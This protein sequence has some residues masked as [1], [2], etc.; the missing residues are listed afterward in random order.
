MGSGADTTMNVV[1]AMAEHESR[2]V[3][4]LKVTMYRPWSAKHFMEV[5]PESV[6][7]ITVLDKTSEGG[8]HGNPLFLDVVATFAE[9]GRTLDLISGGVY[10]I[11]SKAFT[12]NMIK[13]VYD[14]MR[15]P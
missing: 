8:A 10:G 12:P 5:I 11:S 13:A 14:N 6:K 4:L 7:R 15:A 9:S 3:G 2:K 1:D